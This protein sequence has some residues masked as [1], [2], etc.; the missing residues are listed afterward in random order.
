MVKVRETF[1]HHAYRVG[2]L[3]W[4]CDDLTSPLQNVQPPWKREYVPSLK[5]TPFELYIAGEI[6]WEE[7]DILDSQPKFV[8]WFFPYM[9]PLSRKFINF[10]RRLTSLSNEL[11]L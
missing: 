10:V 9:R 3:L 5:A 11:G 7:L 1:P 6:T 8:G 2:D 4:E